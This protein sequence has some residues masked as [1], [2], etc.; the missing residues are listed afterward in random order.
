MVDWAGL[1]RCTSEECTLAF[2]SLPDPNSAAGL[3]GLAPFLPGGRRETEEW[4]MRQKQE[5][6]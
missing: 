1:V 4:L 3:G 6:D 5:L 2:R